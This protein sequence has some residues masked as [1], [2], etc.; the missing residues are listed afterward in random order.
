VSDAADIAAPFIAR[1]Q[2]NSANGV[3][4]LADSGRI[5]RAWA[6]L[7]DSAADDN[8]FFHPDFLLPAAAA[9]G[10]GNVALAAVNAGGR[11]IAAAP[12]TTV[13]LGR[14]APAVR[15]WSHEYGPM[16]VPLLDAARIDEAAAALLR[17]LSPA[18][19]TVAV[20]IPDLPLDGAVAQALARAS[21]ASRRSTTVI[22]RH[23]RAIALRSGEGAYDAT[24]GLSAHRRH[25]YA[26]LLRRLGDQGAVT[27]E[28]AY[29]AEAVR[30]AFDEFLAL[31]AA[32]WK[33]EAKTALAAQPG[34]AEF[35]RRAVAARAEAGAMRIHSL[36]LGGRMIAG[37]VSFVS[38]GTAFTWKI[39]YDE[40][41]A[42]ASPGAQVM[43]AATE[44][45]LGEAQVRRLDS[46]AGPNHVLVDPLLRDRMA[47]GT[48]VIS[49]VGEGTLYRAGLAAAKL[50]GAAIEQA[51][52][53]RKRLR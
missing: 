33:G 26:R 30:A 9:F 22:G 18:R 10:R 46:C 51:K 27:I 24:A 37:L 16:G 47:M 13:R 15:L 49:P 12:F 2:P 19:S 48:F 23:A 21:R 29:Q 17:E 50:E 4:A 11:V 45:L 38:G 6:S 42:K 53:L 41:H 20:I 28:A 3:L 34:L 14:I 35:A 5:V 40:G 25:E 44:S 36:R 43:I 7:A 52:R 1:G 8:V 39:A 32:G 31:E